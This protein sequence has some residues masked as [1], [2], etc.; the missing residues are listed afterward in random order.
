M[1]DPPNE[2]CELCP[3]Q[4]LDAP[5]ALRPML[6]VLYH[7]K[8][9]TSLSLQFLVLSGE[10]SAPTTLIDVLPVDTGMNPEVVYASLHDAPHCLLLPLV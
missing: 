3:W 2:S 1:H 7:Q 4:R 8:C 6:L 5:V 10:L 9:L